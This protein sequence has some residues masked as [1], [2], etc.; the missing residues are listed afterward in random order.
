MGEAE[1]QAVWK[2][3]EVGVV[4]LGHAHGS[5]SN[6]C[7]L[8][9]ATGREGRKV[10]AGWRPQLARE[11]SKA[12]QVVVCSCGSCIQHQ[13]CLGENTSITKSGKRAKDTTKR[14]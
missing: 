12:D 3:W 5:S 10:L 1:C 7:I 8:S 4:G 9:T 11:G 13:D 6:I 14:T 2:R